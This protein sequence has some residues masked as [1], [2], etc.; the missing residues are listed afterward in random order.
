MTDLA[1]HIQTTVLMD[2]HEHMNKEA[3]YLEDGPDVLQD[4]FDNYVTADLVVA[5]ASPQAIER[6]IDSHNSDLE[7]RWEG[8]RQAWQRC[9]FTGYGQAVAFIARNVY[10]MEEITL[11]GVQAAQKLNLQRRQPGERLRILKEEAK[12]DHIQVNELPPTWKVEPDRSGHDFFL[13]DL[14][15]VDFVNG[16]LDVEVLRAEVGV[17]VNDLASLRAALTT[18]F[19]KYAPLAVAVKSQHA[20]QR[21][22][23]WQERTDADVERVLSKRLRGESLSETEKLCLGDWCLG[24][25]AELAAQHHLPFKIHTGYLAGYGR[26]TI[27]K[28]RAGNL[29]GLLIRYPQTRFILMHI[30]YPYDRELVALAKHFPNV[31]LDLCWAWSIDPYSTMDFVRRMIHTVPSHKLFVFGGDTF[32]P[33]AAVAYAAQA[34]QWLTRALQAEVDDTFLTEKQA[35]ALATRFMRENQLACFDLAR[36]RAAIKQAL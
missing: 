15:W 36:T 4:L 28:L 29:C 22:L 18:L 30:A 31:Y 25:G 3:R 33:S 1:Q 26:M 20:Y 13:Y 10:G 9:Q 7:R 17:E 21:T 19:A 34:R 24:L 8:V 14:G 32:W 35:I 2:T 16:D 12:L 5:G 6:L 11:S 27:E 23:N